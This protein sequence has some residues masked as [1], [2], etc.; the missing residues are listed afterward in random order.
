M[1]VF[2]I[3]DSLVFSETRQGNLQTDTIITRATGGREVGAKS[4]RGIR[5]F[6]YEKVKLERRR[7]LV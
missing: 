2:A 1:H 6:N 3:M 7:R 4:I 5:K